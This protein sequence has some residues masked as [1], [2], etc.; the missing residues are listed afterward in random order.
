MHPISLRKIVPALLAIAALG[1]LSTQSA[2]AHERRSVDK[3]S[4]V[5]GFND[6]PALQGEPNGMQ[7]TVTVPAESNRPVEGL[8]DTLKAKGVS[9]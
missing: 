8:A 9:L 2:F 6:E 7:L 4:L 1:L 3:Y 5:V